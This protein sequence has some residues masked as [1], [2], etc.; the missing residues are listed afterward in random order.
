M[1]TINTKSLLLLA[2]LSFFI[3]GHSFAKSTVKE[4]PFYG[5]EIEASEV[6][7]LDSVIKDFSTYKGK[8]IVME[9]K[10]EKVCEAKGC[11]MTLQGTD[12]TFR[13]KFKDY[14]FFVPISLI[15]KKV[16]VQG[17]V[18]RKEVSIKDTKHYLKDAGAS[19]E[20]IEAVKK[21]TIEYRIV[22]EGVKAI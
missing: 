17:E 3:G 2:C 20:K 6:V 13:V 4:A 10:V 18:I 1:K 11:W 21:P 5:E 8:K 15:G 12:K 19:E 7:A 22:A 14:S 16:W 9:A